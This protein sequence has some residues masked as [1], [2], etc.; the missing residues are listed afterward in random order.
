MQAPDLRGLTWPAA[1]QMS[2]QVAQQALAAGPDKDGAVA[3]AEWALME[4]R[5]LIA[6]HDSS[7]ATATQQQQLQ[8]QRVDTLL[9]SLQL[10]LWQGHK[11]MMSDQLRVGADLRSS[12]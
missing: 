3:A 1:L 4:C 12:L 5:T 9:A 11:V 7:S 2:L 8:Q 6:S 10:A